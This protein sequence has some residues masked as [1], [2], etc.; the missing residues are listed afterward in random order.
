[1][2]SPVKGEGPLYAKFLKLRGNAREAIMRAKV[3]SLVGFGGEVDG[4]LS[5]LKFGASTK[6]IKAS[7]SKMK[8][9]LLV[10]LDNRADAIAT[11]RQQQLGKKGFIGAKVNAKALL[12]DPRYLRK[13]AKAKQSIQQLAASR[14]RLAERRLRSALL[15]KN[16]AAYE[17]ELSQIRNYW[18]MSASNAM[19][20]VDKEQQKRVYADA[21]V[22]ALR[23]V[24]GFN[25]PWYGGDE[26]CERYAL[27]RHPEQLRILA[28]LG[29]AVDEEEGVYH[30]DSLPSHPHPWCG[31]QAEPVG[32]SKRASGRLAAPKIAERTAAVRKE[33]EQIAST[34]ISNLGILS[35]RAG[36]SHSPV[37]FLKRAQSTARSRV[38]SARGSRVSGQ[39]TP[40][41]TEQLA[42]E[43]DLVK[44]VKKAIHE[45]TG[46]KVT[47]KYRTF[48]NAKD[49]KKAVGRRA[50]SIDGMY[51]PTTKE[52]FINPQLS[53]DLMY[54]FDDAVAAVDYGESVV[55]AY[56]HEGLHSVSKAAGNPFLHNFL[57]WEEGV[58]ESL[59]RS[60]TRDVFRGVKGF[61]I[62]GGAYDKEVKFFQ[63]VVK[64]M[65]GKQSVET[66]ATDL[67]KASTGGDRM[68]AILL[69]YTRGLDKKTVRRYALKQY[70]GF[71]QAFDEADDFGYR[72]HEMKTAAD[73]RKMLSLLKNLEKKASAAWK[74]IG[75]KA[76]P[77]ST[78]QMTKAAT[79]TS[80]RA[81]AAK[82]TRAKLVTSAKS[83]V[84]AYKKTAVSQ[85]RARAADLSDDALTMGEDKVWRSGKGKVASKQAAAR[86][87]ELRV[88]PAW[89][90]VR[91]SP[92]PNSG[93]Q[94]VGFDVKGR[95]QY[96]Y[97]SMHTEEKAAEKFAR[98]RAFDKKLPDIRKQIAA[99]I[100][101]GDEEA[102]ILRLIDRTGFRPGSMAE[103]GAT[104]QA[105][106]ASTLQAEHVKISGSRLEF[107]F[108]GKKGVKIHK[109]LDDA[110]L[111]K[112]LRPRVAKGGALFDTASTRLRRYVKK[113]AGDF[114]VKDFRTW[115]GTARALEEVAARPIPTTA[116]EFATVQK[117]VVESVASHL[118]NTPA[119]A[120]G[121]YI[122][123]AVWSRWEEQQALLRKIKGLP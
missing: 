114:K 43:E 13:G 75:T 21:G 66:V 82:A 68:E 48:G 103:T 46:S 22:L 17:K 96:L 73:E 39:L 110:E 28:R 120:K 109:V 78:G 76:V 26:I 10:S 97:S 18:K 30:I 9:Q 45:Q 12:R 15:S 98:L 29:I 65:P 1:M 55:G 25:H 69:R 72:Y 4:S 67:L 90:D 71:A 93:L 5:K 79:K 8:K 111:A 14:T 47:A 115:N 74:D 6:K 70:N 104:T 44:F 61:K 23:W 112:L 113:I 117:E 52:V 33:M 60:M 36:L 89:R 51:V 40:L 118:G 106:G 108:I 42:D 27:T 56:I 11:L 95:K 87:K 91:L 84:A 83:R 34:R 123:P 101:A 99:G 49:W 53:E 94:A 7:L 100:E 59:A 86:I 62:Y 57:Y 3:S 64:G 107:N 81:S 35:R 85:T 116:A 119:V 16:P 2:P 92:D 32:A 63:K 31:C 41:N 105:Y 54:L 19:G 20:V 38:A 24:L 58:V 122:D 88:P 50:G 121:S 37:E 80:V 77:T 102:V